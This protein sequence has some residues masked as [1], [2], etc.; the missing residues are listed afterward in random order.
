MADAEALAGQ[1]AATVADLQAY[2]EV[3]A[4]EIAGPLVTATQEKAAEQIAELEHEA[5]MQKQ[6]DGDLITELRRQLDAA[7][8]SR[9]REFDELKELRELRKRVVQRL[10]VQATGP[11]GEKWASYDA[12]VGAIWPEKETEPPQ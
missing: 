9:D 6:R 4:D 5:A 2:I 8:K 3:R 11:H 10:Y 7:V 12:L 1:L